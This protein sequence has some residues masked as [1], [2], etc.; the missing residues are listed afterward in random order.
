MLISDL[1]TDQRARRENERLA[2]EYKELAEELSKDDWNML[3]WLGLFGSGTLEG[4]EMDGRRALEVSRSPAYLH[5]LACVEAELG[6]VK[7]AHD[8]LVEE[9]RANA[10]DGP[11][12]EDWYPWGRIAEQLG[13]HDTAESDYKRVPADED[14]SP[15][16]TAALAKKRLGLSENAVR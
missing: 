15:I 4:A 11:M 1:A 16:A 5:T 13:L 12:P 2:S 14:S 9:Q 6:K 3:A 10:D 8:L 7:E